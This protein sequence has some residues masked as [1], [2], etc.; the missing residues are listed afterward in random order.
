[1]IRVTIVTI[2]CL[3]RLRTTRT[4]VKLYYNSRHYCT[5]NRL[6]YIAILLLL[7]SSST[8]VCHVQSIGR[9]T[10]WFHDTTLQPRALQCGLNSCVAKVNV[11][12]TTPHPTRSNFMYVTTIA[13]AHIV[14][15]MLLELSLCCD[16]RKCFSS[17]CQACKHVSVYAC[18]TSLTVQTKSST[19]VPST[20]SDSMPKQLQ[21]NSYHHQLVVQSA[22][23]TQ[24]PCTCHMRRG[25]ATL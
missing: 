11:Y 3:I 9:F 4:V 22:Q 16:W 17:V 23:R 20:A 19:S 14:V 18:Q 21:Y 8:V 1:M 2:R 15:L 10:S 13:D 24:R 6:R 7:Y 12:M 25:K 5:I